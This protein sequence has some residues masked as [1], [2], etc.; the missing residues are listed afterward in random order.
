MKGETGNPWLQIPLEDYEGHMSAS[1]VQQLQ[2][3]D[4]VFKDIL[5]E[6]SPKSLCVLGSTAGN[7]FQHLIQ[8]TLD[9]VVGVDINFKYTA[10]CRAWFIQDVPNLQL[11]CADLNELELTDS[12]FDLIHAALI[13]EYVDVEK[14]LS[15]IYRW[16]K[17]DGR[18]S[19][20]L[21]L[22]CENSAAVSE[23]QYQSVKV[24]VPFIKLVEPD[25]LKRKAEKLQL[26]CE[27]ETEIKLS[28][29]KRFIKAYFKK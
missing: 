11:I 5:N 8:R 23:T 17:P 10:E 3:L 14:L 22:P 20:V 29:G 13:F 16:L 4:E 1:N 24:L 26:I 15:K 2:M 6:F 28:T 19:V 12:I 27:E 9:R 18:L 21:Q 7:G 25:E